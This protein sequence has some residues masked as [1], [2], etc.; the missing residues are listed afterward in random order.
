M[1]NKIIVRREIIMKKENQKPEDP[2]KKEYKFYSLFSK[3][4][5]PN[6]N[7]KKSQEKDGTNRK[8]HKDTK[9]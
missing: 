4:V 7:A 5:N 9:K 1:L 8:I 6:P 3:I 2:I